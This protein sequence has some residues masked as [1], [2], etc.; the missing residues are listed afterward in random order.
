MV[1]DAADP[2]RLAE[3]WALALDY[4]FEPPPK[5]FETWEDFARSIPGVNAGEQSIGMGVTH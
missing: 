3:F 2:A 5:G 1:L 4:V